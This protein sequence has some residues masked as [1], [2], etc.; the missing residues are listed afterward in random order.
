MAESDLLAL[1]KWLDARKSPTLVQ[2][3]RREYERLKS[4]WGLP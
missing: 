4:A 2:L 1:I 3:P